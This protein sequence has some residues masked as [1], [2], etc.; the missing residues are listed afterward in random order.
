LEIKALDAKRALEA[1]R[2]G[3]PNRDAVQALGSHQTAVEQKF[4]ALLDALKQDSLPEGILLSGGFGSGK[5]HLLEYLEH[6]ALLANCVCSRIVVSKETPLFD[7]GKV[8]KSAVEQATVPGRTGQAIQE[9]AHMLRPGSDRYAEFYRWATAKT[10]GLPE[11]FAASLFVHE[12][13]GN[14]PELVEEMTSFW[15]GD[16]L[17]VARVKEGLRKLGASK[18]FDVRPVKVKDLGLPRFAFASRLIRAAGFA[19]WVLLIDEVELVGRYSRLQRARSY[20]EVA[21]WLGTGDGHPGGIGAVMAITDDF[22]LA[23]LQQKSDRDL[24]GEILQRKATSEYQAMVESAERG[25]KLIERN[26]LPLA[27]PDS[28]VLIATHNGLRS[29]HAKAFD[30]SPPELSVGVQ[31]LQRPMRSYVRRWLNEWDLRRL[32]PDATVDI[33]EQDIGVGYEED[34]DLEVSSDDADQ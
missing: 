15:A 3:V 31:S 12:R 4:V 23:V 1:L 17:T 30:W 19:G 9:I 5:S 8:F 7:L 32:Y 25:M 34:H 13:L 16:R 24:I 10:S 18:V 27:P 14:D 29:I 26:A 6:K 22:T 28:S 21:R 33:V 20:A 2:N 11:V